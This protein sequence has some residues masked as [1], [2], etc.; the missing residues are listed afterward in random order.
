MKK[1]LSLSL[2]LVST[3]HAANA[4]TNLV[5]VSERGVSNSHDSS[6]VVIQVNSIEQWN[7]EGVKAQ[8]QNTGTFQ[9]KFWCV[10]GR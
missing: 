6:S 9:T 5:L 8:K 3:P 7:E 10:E 2:L 4:E 1:I